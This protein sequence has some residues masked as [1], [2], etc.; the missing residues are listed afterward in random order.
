MKLQIRDEMA[1]GKWQILYAI[2]WFACMTQFAYLCHGF[3]MSCL[4]IIEFVQAI[5][6]K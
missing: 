4:I 6:N 3:Y 5:D 2:I 1:S